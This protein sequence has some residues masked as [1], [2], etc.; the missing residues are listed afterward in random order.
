MWKV[1]NRQMHWGRKQIRGYLGLGW[2]KGK[3]GDDSWWVQ[4]GFEEW[5]KC[6]KCS[7]VKGAQQ[8]LAKCWESDLS[9]RFVIWIKHYV[10]ITAESSKISKLL[11]NHIS[12]SLKLI[13][14][15]QWLASLIKQT[16]KFG[17]VILPFE[18]MYSHLVGLKK[19]EYLCR[20][21]FM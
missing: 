16:M 20:H 13:Y 2:G 9:W 12:S 10:M 6:S 1:Q 15:N 8:L 3:D 7:V 21:S 19:L 17:S 11:I 5:G 18:Q 14:S 4:G